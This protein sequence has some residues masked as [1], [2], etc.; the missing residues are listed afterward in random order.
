MDGE[1]A[2]SSSS[3]EEQGIE[4]AVIFPFVTHHSWK[5]RWDRTKTQGRFNVTV[6]TA[7]TAR[8]RATAHFSSVL[9]V[10]WLGFGSGQR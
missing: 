10:Y 6:R 5:L 1:E 8:G 4:C 9:V 7:A 3:L 2:D